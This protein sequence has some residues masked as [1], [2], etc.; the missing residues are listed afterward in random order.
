M[1]YRSTLKHVV[2]SSYKQMLFVIYKLNKY[3]FQLLVLEIR[4][5][6]YYNGNKQKLLCVYYLHFLLY[7]VDNVLL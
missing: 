6:I 3:V 2:E 1:R 4:L 7:L 5:I